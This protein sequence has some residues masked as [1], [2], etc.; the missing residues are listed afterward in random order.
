[1]RK[2][3]KKKSVTRHRMEIELGILG[4][5]LLDMDF[6]IEETEKALSYGINRLRADDFLNSDNAALFEAIKELYESGINERD[7]ITMEL[8][9]KMDESFLSYVINFS[10][11]SFRLFKLHVEELIK[12][13][14]ED[15][16]QELLSKALKGELQEEE[17]FKQIAELNKRL[18]EQ[19][20][21]ADIAVLEAIK[22]LEGGEIN[23]I[24]TGFP[25]LDN[26]VVFRPE[27]I[28]IIG[29]R[30]GVGK[31]AT[32][33]YMSYWQMK[34]ENRKVLFFSMELSAKQ[35][36][37]RYISLVTGIP[38]RKILRNDLTPEEKE[39]ILF[40]GDEI[41]E[42]PLTI[43]DNP[44][45]K[46][47][48]IRSKVLEH[49]PDIVYIDYVQRM[50]PHK[51]YNSLRE[52]INE[53]S[54]ELTSISKELKVPIVVLAQLS[55][56]AEKEPPGFRHLKESGQLE[57]DASNVILLHR[58]KEDPYS[59]KFIIAKCREGDVKHPTFSFVNGFPTPEIVQK[60]GEKEEAVKAV[61]EEDDTDIFDF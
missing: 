51:K 36:I 43:Y 10:L 41:R 47:H 32:A 7:K 13:S 2:K 42:L 46:I 56:M 49:Q 50:V 58:T 54:I 11:M 28:S 27:E 25:L 3:E 61:Q 33:I 44:N 30:P 38:L 55:R 1:M 4:T 6:P 9:K 60:E 40:A 19:E 23:G 29:A 17:V 22:D 39:K 16:K 52:F 37:Q 14:V 26:Y 20:K 5:M 59:I 31:T 24:T 15:K 48:T 18:Q 45:L 21:D 12:L 8:K 53:V 57:Q 35:L 34:L